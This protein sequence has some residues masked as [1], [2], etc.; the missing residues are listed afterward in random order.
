M[1]AYRL[2]AR[3][4]L[5]AAIGNFSTAA[6]ADLVPPSDC[7]STNPPVMACAGKAAGDA[8]TFPS[9]TSG[10]CAALKCG[11]QSALSCVALGAN[12]PKT[13]CSVH[14]GQAATSASCA[15]GAAMLLLAVALHR[16]RAVASLRR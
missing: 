8:C 9:G 7:A 5:L 11:T 12:E 16:R 6:W 1:S 13:G 14:P 3:I 10:S 4:M 15:A 2:L